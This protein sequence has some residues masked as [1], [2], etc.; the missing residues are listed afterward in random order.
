MGPKNRIFHRKPFSTS[1]RYQQQIVWYVILP[2]IQYLGQPIHVYAKKERFKDV[3][4]WI[5][6]V[7][8]YLDSC[9]VLSEIKFF[10]QAFL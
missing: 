2:R 6:G 10:F 1:D 3:H 5:A 9:G 7:R 4:K 8:V